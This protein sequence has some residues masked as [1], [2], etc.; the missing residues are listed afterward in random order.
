MMK[1][2]EHRQTNKLTDGQTLATKCI[3]SLLP[4][5][6]QSIIISRKNTLMNSI[7]FFPLVNRVPNR[8]KNVCVCPGK[9]VS[10]FTMPSYSDRI[11]ASLYT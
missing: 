6:A 11:E 8:G 2:I 9:N 5:A 10:L 3:I 7:E 1:S 4:N